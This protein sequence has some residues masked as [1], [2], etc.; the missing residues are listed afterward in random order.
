MRIAKEF[1]RNL[2]DTFL[3]T[4]KLFSAGKRFINRHCTADFSLMEKMHRDGKTFQ[5]HAAH[6]FNWEWLNHHYALHW[7]QPLVAVYMPLANRTF[8]KVFYR[9]R[10]RY[11]TVMLPATDMKNSFLPWRKR[12][13]G[14]VLVADQNPGHPGNSYWFGFF[15]RPAPFVRGPERSAREKACPVIFAFVRKIKRGYYHT[16][17]TLVTE[18]ASQLPEVELTRLYVKSLQE[19][20]AAQ[21]SMWLWSHRRWKHVWQEEHGPVYTA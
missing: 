8:E 15:G 19:V 3:E 14:L 16:D 6:Q 20:I 12:E 17:F 2:V 1:Y 9:M 4:L 13:H 7:P 10:T 11:A 5:V 18:D 21:P